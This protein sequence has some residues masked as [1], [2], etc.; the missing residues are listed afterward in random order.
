MDIEFERILAES[1]NNTNNNNN[2]PI[3][4]SEANN[5]NEIFVGNEVKTEN[6]NGIT[7]GDREVVKKPFVSSKK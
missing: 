1:F 6:A 4:T 7:D 5:V 2:V 3:S